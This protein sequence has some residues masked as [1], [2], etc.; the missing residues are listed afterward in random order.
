MGGFKT[1]ESFEVN[2][3]HVTWLDEMAK[4]HDL[5]D[6]DKALRA[7]LDYAMTDGDEE[8]IFTKI[9]CHQC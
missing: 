7:L 6:R 9:R 8:D 4:K 5:P 1:T 3:Q 2:E